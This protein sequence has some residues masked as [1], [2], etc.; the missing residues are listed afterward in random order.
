MFLLFFGGVV[1]GRATDAGYFRHCFCFGVAMQ[2]FGVLMASLAKEYYQILLSQGIC[3]GLG[4]GFV[5]TPAL[6]VMSSYFKTKRSLAVGIAAAGSSTGGMVYP[7][8]VN[9]LLRHSSVGYGWTMRIFAFIML[10]TQ[11]PSL[12]AYRPYLP[13]RAAGPFVDWS[14]FRQKSWVFFAVG[15]FLNF[16]G[17]YLAFFYLG[18]YTRETFHLESSVNLLIVLNGVSAIGRIVPNVLGERYTGILNMTILVTLVCALLIYC[19]AAIRSVTGLY[20]WAVAYGIFAGGIQA[21][22][23]ALATQQAPEPDKVGTWTGM[24]LTMV[25]FAGLT[26]GP[27][28]GAIIKANGGSYLGAQIFSGTSMIL[29][30]ILL[31]LSRCSRVGTSWRAKV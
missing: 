27:I 22:F 15:M 13:K 25:S 11:V 8:M 5:F 24:T 21:L 12:I 31:T 7:A 29:G 28:H 2:V 3:V 6:S 26:L 1:S 4:S 17:L 14:A 16:W 9:S 23:P 19:W 10:A 18:I 30:A 20:V